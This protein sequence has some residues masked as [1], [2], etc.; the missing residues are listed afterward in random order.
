M[1]KALVRVLAL[2]RLTLNLRTFRVTA[3]ERVSLTSDGTVNC[4]G[5]GCNANGTFI[6]LEAERPNAR[7]LYEVLKKVRILKIEVEVSGLPRQL[8]SRLEFLTGKPISD[9]A[10]VKY[11][12]RAMP[13]FEELAL[14]LNDLNLP[15]HPQSNPQPH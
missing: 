5:G 6:I 8:L 4:L 12:W 3:S 15:T 10:V 11:T 2:G 13:S 7:E 14:A 9:D 1:P